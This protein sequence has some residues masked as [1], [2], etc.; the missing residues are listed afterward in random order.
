MRLHY[1]NYPKVWDCNNSTGNFNVGRKIISPV[2]NR[3]RL[4][5][6]VW[7]FKFDREFHRNL[8]AIIYYVDVAMDGAWGRVGQ[9][10]LPNYNSCI[11][12]GNVVIV[13]TPAMCPSIVCHSVLGCWIVKNVGSNWGPN[14]WQG[15]VTRPPL[16]LS[17]S[18]LPRK[19]RWFQRRPVRFLN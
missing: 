19:S 1:L 14:E 10:I 16:R 8:C 5:F 6:I 15:P 7:N 9:L 3:R 4:I 13:L 2:H 11:F 18:P 17:F 12:K